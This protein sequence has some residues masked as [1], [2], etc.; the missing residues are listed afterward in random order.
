[1][2]AAR[3]LHAS[4]EAVVLVGRVKSTR[5]ANSSSELYRFPLVRNRPTPSTC[6]ERLVDATEQGGQVQTRWL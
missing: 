3:I 1:M 2:E 4:L 6:C 5:S